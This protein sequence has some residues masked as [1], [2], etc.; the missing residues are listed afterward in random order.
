LRLRAFARENLNPHPANR[1]L[2]TRFE[3]KILNPP[4]PAS[5]ERRR[6]NDSRKAAKVQSFK[7]PEMQNPFFL[8]ASAP[9]RDTILQSK[10]QS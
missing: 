4:S 8:C 1:E 7:N 10:P 5:G 9:F 3:Q 6:K 2:I